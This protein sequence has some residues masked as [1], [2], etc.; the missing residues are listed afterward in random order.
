MTQTKAKSLF[1]TCCN[2]GSGF[3]LAYLSWVFVIPKIFDMNTIAEQGFWVTVYF[4]ALSVV[5]G[6]IWRRG[7]NK[8]EK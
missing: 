7:F 1:E 8:K 4:T 6:Y 5:R 2:V 3:I